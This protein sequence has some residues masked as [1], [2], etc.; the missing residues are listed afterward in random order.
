MFLSQ[1]PRVYRF[2]ASPTF[3]EISCFIY[4]STRH[5]CEHREKRAGAG[6][7]NASQLSSMLVSL[8]SEPRTRS[9]TLDICVFVLSPETTDC[10]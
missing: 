6:G 4:F 2:L 1:L 8:E 3:L 10:K 5:E 9:K 7:L